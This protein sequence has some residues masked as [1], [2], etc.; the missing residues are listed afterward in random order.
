MLSLDPQPLHKQR[1]RVANGP[2]R[3]EPLPVLH[4]LFNHQFSGLGCKRWP[5]MQARGEG[6]G[7][8]DSRGQ[9]EKGEVL[10]GKWVVVHSGTR[11]AVKGPAEI[12]V[13]GG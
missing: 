12:P 11:Q 5:N 6:R 8:Q 4:R 1:C 10:P 9:W 3:G 2:Q 7:S 13:H